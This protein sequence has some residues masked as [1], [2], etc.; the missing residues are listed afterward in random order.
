MIW[1]QQL[2]DSTVCEAFLVSIP[3]LILT[4]KASL[5]D[6]ATEAQRTGARQLPGPVCRTKC[7]SLGRVPHSSHHTV[8]TA[9]LTLYSK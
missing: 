3:H 9:H 4:F 1:G 2:W 6:R 8:V 5:R 7:L